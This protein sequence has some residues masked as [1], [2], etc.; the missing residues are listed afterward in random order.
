MRELHLEGITNNT[1]SQHTSLLNQYQHKIELINKRIIF[2]NRLL[3]AVGTLM[4]VIQAL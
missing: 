1:A 3:I 4:L 2:C